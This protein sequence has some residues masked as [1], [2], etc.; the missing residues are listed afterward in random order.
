MPT[1]W[2]EGWHSPRGTYLWLHYF[3]AGQSLCG[4]WRMRTLIWD[5]VEPQGRKCARCRRVLERE[6]AAKAG[7]S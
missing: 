5:G 6:A 7:R 3:R 4:S 1:R 2:E